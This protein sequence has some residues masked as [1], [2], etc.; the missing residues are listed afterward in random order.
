MQRFVA[1]RALLANAAAWRW[2]RKQGCGQVWARYAASH[3]NLCRPC[4]VTVRLEGYT[5]VHTWWRAG[6][7]VGGMAAKVLK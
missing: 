7:K 3:T 2:A 1:A 6:S 4:T 5:S